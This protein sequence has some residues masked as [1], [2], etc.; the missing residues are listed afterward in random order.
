MTS[1]N[2]GE[3]YSYRPDIDGLRCIAVVSVI[4]Y[5]FNKELL[6]GGFLGVDVFFV[7]SGF[8]ITGNIIRDWQKGTFSF[9][10]FYRRRVKRIAPV[11]AFVIL[12][13]LIA[14]QFIFLPE[15]Y[16]RLADSA[17]YS[18]LSLANF[19]STYV[20]DNG[21]FAPSSE[22]RP[23]LHYWSLSV[24]EQFYFLWPMLLLFGLCFRA[25]Y[26]LPLTILLASVSVIAAEYMSHSNPDFSYYMLPTRAGELLCGACLAFFLPRISRSSYRGANV[27]SFCLGVV[28]V[29]LIA[30]SFVMLNEEAPF[31]GYMA[32]P[33]CVGAMLAIASGS[34]HYG[35]LHSFIGNKIFVSVGLISY[36]LYLW[37]WPVL[38]F[39]RYW[40]GGENE[41]EPLVV[42]VVLSVFTYFLIER[43]IRAASGTFA[44][45]FVKFYLIPTFLILLI[46]IGV[47]ASGGFGYLA[48]N[49]ENIARFDKADVA[50]QPA[51][52]L[53][54]VCQFSR[55]K[56]SSL[57]S[58]NCIINSYSE[59][60][61]L[62]WGDSNSAHY[63]GVVKAIADK[64]GF[65]FR[66]VAHSSCAP[67]V[68]NA[69]VYA[70]AKRAEDC[71][72][73][74]RL[75][76]NRLDDYRAF[77]ISASWNGVLSRGGEDFL[78]DLKTTVE[79]LT[80]GGRPVYVLGRV[81]ILKGVSA[82]CAMRKLTVV[83]S[84]C[85]SRFSV[86][87]ESVQ[88]VNRAIEDVVTSAG[89]KY[90]DF[91]SI[92]C[93]KG[94]CGPFVEGEMIYFDSGHISALGGEVFA[95]SVIDSGRYSD[96]F[97][98]LDEL[99]PINKS[100][101]S[102]DEINWSDTILSLHDY[103]RD[104][105]VMDARG[106]RLIDDSTGE[107]VT[108]TTSVEFS[109]PESGERLALRVVVSEGAG[110]PLVRMRVTGGDE[111]ILQYDY[112]ADF[113]RRLFRPKN[114]GIKALWSSA[115]EGGSLTLRFLSE[116]LYG[117]VK[118]E[119]ILYGGAVSD[120]GGYSKNAKGEVLV[121]DLSVVKVSAM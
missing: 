113:S 42:M 80:S 81:P 8:L 29:G 63:V 49:S 17:I 77:I 46:S 104:A 53:P 92:L 105:S 21:Y 96:F 62:M 119:V 18:Q 64:E 37:H 12:A 60:S 30:G 88:K 47:K 87:V 26:V 76:Q 33:V 102:F 66:N 9:L 86:P 72:V 94:V 1:S 11:S 51:I 100:E 111:K 116:K 110:L 45:V 32:L 10:D 50:P 3:S 83:G 54:Y 36:S 27:L 82:S 44:P 118:V 65:S 112:I 120:S 40:G 93:G 15:D 25:R 115:S 101:L 97:D 68:R 39:W 114:E 106:L 28:G 59:P 109:A 107:Y 48:W 14:G 99:S 91:N 55:L 23:L 16:A 20:V 24:E 52:V 121:E 35:V 67:L 4:L 103:G 117:D 22:F 2:V 85:E 73:S 98:G 13:A 5:H 90:I 95:K 6:S 19:Y 31:P 61:V 78:S 75:I 43:P 41:L 56:P 84:R 38:A 57:T 70:P 69:D 74:S 7:I 89:G 34:I 108:E 58:K 79:T 71:R